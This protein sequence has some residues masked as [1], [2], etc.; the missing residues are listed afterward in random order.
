MRNA[1]L[2]KQEIIFNKWGKKFI[3]DTL[4]MED[5]V[6]GDW[7][8]INGNN[9]VM[10]VA[11]TTDKKIILVR[12]YRYTIKQFTYEN[13]AGGVEKGES[14]TEAVTREFLEETGY[15][16]G[17]VVSLGSYYDLPTETTHWCHIFLATDCQFVSPPLFDK[18]VEKYFEISIETHDFQ[19][20]F[21]DLGTEN[22][23]LK[24]AEHSYGIMLAHRYL[25]KHKLL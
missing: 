8:Y 12:Q 16:V 17:K 11:L 10:V 5:G 13:C 19:K 15:K 6:I 7:A 4:Q 2:L 20:V 1:K 22:S 3:V 9:G 18:D 25:E 14:D 23:L 24:S 21:D